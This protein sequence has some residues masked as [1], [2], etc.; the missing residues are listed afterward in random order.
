MTN[1]IYHPTKTVKGFACSFWFSDRDCSLYA[2]LIKQAGWDEKTQNGTFKG[3]LKDPN[4]KVN[5]K[6]SWIEASAILDCIERNR[7]FNT[8]HD[9]DDFPKAITFTPWMG[10]AFTDGEGNQRPAT[11]NGF[12]FTITVKNKQDTT[13]QNAFFIGLTFAEARYIREF[14]IHALHKH[15]KKTSTPNFEN[16]SI[17]DNEDQVVKHPANNSPSIQSNDGILDF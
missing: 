2:T 15:F 17:R 14:L 11:Q 13:Q 8:Y 4:K 1:H 16:A 9:Q 10:K 6:L 5:I 12:S 3:S 7:P